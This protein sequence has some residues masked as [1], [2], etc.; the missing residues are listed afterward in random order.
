MDRKRIFGSGL[1]CF[2]VGIIAILIVYPL[3]LLLKIPKIQMADYYSNLI[4]ILAI[5]LTLAVEIWGF[6]SLP[7][8]KRGNDLMTGKAYKYLRHPIYAGFLDFFVFG[9]GFYLKS[10]GVLISGVILIFICGRLVDAEEK[11][12]IKKF[13]KKYIDYQKRTKK[14]IPFVY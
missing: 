10:F 8:N 12:M 9:L 7:I 13:G 1:A 4:F 5:I 2:T 11:Y 6:I 3:E 14:F